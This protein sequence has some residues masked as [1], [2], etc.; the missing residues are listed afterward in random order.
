MSERGFEKELGLKPDS[1]T[2]AGWLPLGVVEREAS[3]VVTEPA[4][5][6]PFSQLP[7]FVWLS[8]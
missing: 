4:E 6:S 7:F 8:Q 1:A 2:V 3:E 5:H